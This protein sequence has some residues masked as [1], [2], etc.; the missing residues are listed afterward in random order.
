MSKRKKSH[1]NTTLN[2]QI[3]QYYSRIG[4][5]VSTAIILSAAVIINFNRVIY[6]DFT[7]GVYDTIEVASMTLM[8]YM[9][10]A[11]IAAITAVGVIRY[12][13]LSAVKRRHSGYRNGYRSWEKG[14]FRG[15]Y[16]W[17]VRMNILMTLPTN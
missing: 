12:Y 4:L 14:M 3:S 5:L 10:S 13:R 6:N 15:H 16:E 2:G 7:S 9:I 1:S 17:T 11:V 8:P